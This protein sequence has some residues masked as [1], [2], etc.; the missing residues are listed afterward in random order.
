MAQVKFKSFK[1]RVILDKEGLV[2]VQQKTWLFFWTDVREVILGLWHARMNFGTLAEAQQYIER[3][4]RRN[5]TWSYN[6]ES[7]E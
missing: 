7:Q 5:D 1:H 2:Q 4:E 6:G 3:L